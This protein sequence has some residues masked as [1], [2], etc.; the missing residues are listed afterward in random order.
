MTATRKGIAEDT[1]AS[2]SHRKVAFTPGA[3]LELGQE[4]V[5]DAAAREQRHPR[6]IV[7]LHWL[8]VLCVCMAAGL[9]LIRDEVAGRAVRQWLLEGHRHFGLFVLTL[10]LIR[11]VVRIRAGQLASERGTHI[12]LRAAAALTHIALYA[13]L[14]ALPLLGWA[15]SN[16]QDKPVHFFGLTLPAL[17]S[18]DEDLADSLQ[19]WH[20]DAAWLLLALVV[21]HVS[22]ALWH[23]FVLRDGVLRRML[24]GRRH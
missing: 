15:L 14:L 6:R 16:A 9:I 23:H 17:V 2:A 18:A 20:V 5:A 8:T 7:V 1:S 24:P 3:G 21:L 22:A 10:F 4:A 13:V 11:V 12:L 19:S